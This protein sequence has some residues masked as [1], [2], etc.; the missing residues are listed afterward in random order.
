MRFV[1]ANL[2]Q[3]INLF[4]EAQQ[5]ISQNQLYALKHWRFLG[6]EIVCAELEDVLDLVADALSGGVYFYK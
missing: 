5:T 2:R 6:K 4:A 1:N 3:L